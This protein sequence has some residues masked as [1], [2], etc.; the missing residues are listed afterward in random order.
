[1]E[2]KLCAA[3][4]LRDSF[5]SVF[6]SSLSNQYSRYTIFCEGETKPNYP[7]SRIGTAADCSEKLLNFTSFSDI[8]KKCNRNTATKNNKLVE[9]K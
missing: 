9:T 8:K 1:M 6:L 3:F 4:R 2:A 5:F 7:N